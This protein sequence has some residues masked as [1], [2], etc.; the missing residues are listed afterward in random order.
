MNMRGRGRTKDE[1]VLRQI[2]PKT[3]SETNSEDGNYT[4]KTTQQLHQGQQH[5]TKANRGF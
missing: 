2:E 1:L 5:S 3:K 4:Q